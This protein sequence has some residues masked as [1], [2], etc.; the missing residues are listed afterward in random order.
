MTEVR[1]PTSTHGPLK[2]S[3]PDKSAANRIGDY[4]VRKPLGRGSF[5]RVF[6]GSHFLTGKEVKIISKCIF[7]N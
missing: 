1:S 4:V 6:L 7:T 3:I 2:D 5:S